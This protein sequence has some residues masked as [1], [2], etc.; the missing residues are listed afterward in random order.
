MTYAIVYSSRT[1][2]TA[3]LAE[4]LRSALPAEGCVYFGAPGGD[5]PAA[6]AVFAGF[7]TDKGDC[8]GDAA[9]YL[10]TL[11]CKRIFLFGTAGF[12]G[13][14][15]YFD[16]ILT[17]VRAH[18]P[19]DSAEGG[20]YM[21]QGRMPQAVRRRYEAMAQTDPQKARPML[22]NFDAAMSHP[23]NRDRMHL[24]EAALA[25]LKKE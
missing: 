18:L 8:D 20:T 15:R 12:G 16:A 13:S 1:G 22:E 25:F 2:N 17:R 6:D 9:R 19:E 11:H 3:S 7:W 14:D 23:D 24:S 5:I 21:C 10:E 4:A